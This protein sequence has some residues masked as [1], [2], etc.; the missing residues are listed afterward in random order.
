MLS[1]MGEAGE[2]RK[3]LLCR[4]AGS[5]NR[6]FHDNSTTQEWQYCQLCFGHATQNLKDQ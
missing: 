2:K 5:L 3:G 1:K 6:V 4:K